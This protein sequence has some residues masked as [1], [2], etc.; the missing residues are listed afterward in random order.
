VLELNS[1]SEFNDFVEMA[2]MEAEDQL[3]N[4]D[5]AL[6]VLKFCDAHPIYH[7]QRFEPKPAAPPTLLETTIQ[8]ERSSRE[9][10]IG[11]RLTKSVEVFSSPEFGGA[12]ESRRSLRGLPILLALCALSLGAVLWLGVSFKRSRDEIRGLK[13]EL[14]DLTKEKNNLSSD[15]SHAR[16]LAAQRAVDVQTALAERE[17]KERDANN[18]RHQIQEQFLNSQK[19]KKADNETIRQ[20]QKEITSL[21][22]QNSTPSPTPLPNSTRLPAAK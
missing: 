16:E 12:P 13:N 17:K 10:A 9:P 2:R 19:E 4:D 21:K 1:T 20:L 5:V 11:M 18:L 6:A 8:R 14:Q 7:D 15:A 3:E 22:E